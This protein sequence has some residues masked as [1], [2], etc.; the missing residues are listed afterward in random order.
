MIHK[1][2]IA[3]RGEIAVRIIRTCRQMGIRTVAVFSEP[4]RGALFMRKADEAVAL[5]GARPDESYLRQD[6]IIAAALQ[7]GGDAIHPGY[8]FFA[9]NAAFANACRMAGLVFVGPSAEAIALMGDKLA[10]KNHMQ[11]V[12][13]P[14]LPGADLSTIPEDA[15]LPTAEKIGFPVLVK[16]AAGGGGKGMQVVRDKNNLAD[17]VAGAKR[18][19]KA[20]FGDNRVFLERYI[21]APRHIEIQIFGDSHGNLV[22]LFER[23]CSIQ[24]RHQKIVEETPSPAITPALRAEMGAAAVAA[25]KTIG[26]EGAGTVEFILAPNGEF[27]FLEVNTRLQVEHPVTECITGIDLVRAQLLVADGAPLPP[28]LEKPVSRGHAIEARLYAEDPSS[29]FLPTTGKLARFH[30]P[31]R[32]GLRVDSGVVDGDTVS[33]H[34]DPML[35]KVTAHAPTR[36]E[37]AALL[38]DS[39]SRSQIHGLVTNRDFLVRL[40]QH[41][42]F[43]TGATDT[44]FLER[45]SPVSLGA[46]TLTPAEERLHAIAAALTTQAH[47]AKNAKA[48]PSIPSGWRNNFSAPQQVQFIGTHGTITV[49]YRICRDGS[50]SVTATTQSD[51]A[52]DAARAQEAAQPGTPENS[53]AGSNPQAGPNADLHTTHSESPESPESHEETVH[54]SLPYPEQLEMQTNSV[55]RRY[56]VHCTTVQEEQCVFV[57]SPLGHAVLRVR[58]R[59]PDATRAPDPGSLLAPMPG[60]IVRIA[61]APG[62]IVKKGQ[63]LIVLEAMKME[64]TVH[65]PED[66]QVAEVRV[67]TNEQVETGLVLVVLHT[68][69]QETETTNS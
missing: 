27:W 39:L 65:A 60:K 66:G 34:Y 5:G 42:D 69:T 38:A 35:A 8:G 52:P 9:E 10:A 22:H 48:F 46:P 11:K 21:D 4:D 63:V 55:L 20:A 6:A 26:Y 64:H 37:A 50:A 12:G 40:L 14:V 1:L 49:A 62:D 51:T 54:F 17:A 45:H 16:A 67:E 15:L 68:D 2:L 44:H 28:E 3:N 24:R 33:V 31:A 29:G 43:L 61:A 59:F 36:A 47:N 18:Q 7:V 53:Q 30:V 58:A 41:P 19:A 25:G 23:E 13:V 32:H 57:D 56:S